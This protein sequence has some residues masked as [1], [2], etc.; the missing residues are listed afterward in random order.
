MAKLLAQILG[1]ALLA[2]I[3]L[4]LF[5]GDTQLLRLMNTD[6][7]LDL[8]RIPV[9]AA[10]LYA[11]FMT[12]DDS[13]IN[14]IVLTVGVLYIGMGLLGIISPT[15]FGLLPSGLTGFDIAFHLVTGALGVAAGLMHERHHPSTRAM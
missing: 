3:V 14:A 5:A 12:E 9:A 6:I 1:I 11:G 15:Y 2:F 8:I 4:G 7:A 13:Q 10:L